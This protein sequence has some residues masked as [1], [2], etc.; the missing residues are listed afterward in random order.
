MTR[1]GLTVQVVVGFVAA[2]MVLVLAPSATSQADPSQDTAEARK[3]VKTRSLALFGSFG[4]WPP[5]GPVKASARYKWRQKAIKLKNDKFKRKKPVVLYRTSPKGKWRKAA[6]CWLKDSPGS[7]R[8][9]SVRKY[10]GDPIHKNQW[11]YW[12]LCKGFPAKKKKHQEIRIRKWCTFK[13][14]F[15]R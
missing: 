10:K 13:A 9:C 2:T 15:R 3:Y 7:R 5:D 11:V 1:R 8:W 4:G 12:R 14:K 6:R